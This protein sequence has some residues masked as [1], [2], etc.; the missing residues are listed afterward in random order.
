MLC[1]PFGVQPRW[2]PSALEMRFCLPYLMLLVLG[3]SAAGQ[4]PPEKLK[5]GIVSTQ[6]RDVPPALAKLSLQP[7]QALVRS[8]TGL[9][10]EFQLAKD[11]D[12]LA[13]E[14]A[15]NKVHLGMFHGVEFAWIRHKHAELRPLVIAVNHHPHLRAHL[16]VAKDCEAGQFLDLRGKSLGVATGT[17]LHCRLFFE[18]PCQAA[19]H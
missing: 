12:E 7:L 19:G 6:F 18:R 14:L 13:D 4:N 8:E 9:A 3:A 16:V 1:R 2:M 15:A 17:R 10:N 5:I 11:A